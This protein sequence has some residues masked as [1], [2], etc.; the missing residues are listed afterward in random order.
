MSEN[1]IRPRHAL[2]ICGQGL[3]DHH[4]RLPSVGLCAELQPFAILEG[5]QGIWHR[6]SSR[7][8]QT[9]Y[10]ESSFIQPF[11]LFS[12]EG[13]RKER[14]PNNACC[15]YH[16]EVISGHLFYLQWQFQSIC[17]K[18]NQSSDYDLTT[19]PCKMGLCEAVNMQRLCF[20]H[21][22]FTQESRKFIFLF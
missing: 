7:T 4:Y 3:S 5:N 15:F 14:Y 22:E 21:T 11:V 10:T 1:R 17:F 6:L 20:V 19:I 13:Q 16:S 12:L 8:G 9:K 2:S 18:T